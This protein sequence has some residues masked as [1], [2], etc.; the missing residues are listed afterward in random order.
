MVADFKPW[1]EE[2]IKL[3]K[4]Q[5][6]KVK[7]S[8]EENKWIQKVYRNASVVRPQEKKVVITLARREIGLEAALKVIEKM[9]VDEDVLYRDILI[10]ERGYVKTKKFWE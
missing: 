7:V 9:R 4:K 5:V 1:E 3:V 6:K 10:A 2:E 8:P